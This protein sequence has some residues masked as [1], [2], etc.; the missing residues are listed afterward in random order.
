MANTVTATPTAHPAVPD[1][2]YPQDAASG[3]LPPAPW[4]G[5]L[6]DDAALIFPA[7]A[8][9]LWLALRLRR[10]RR[11]R[12]A[13]NRAENTLRG[14]VQ[15][16]SP[17]VEQEFFRMLVQQLAKGLGARYALVGELNAR[18]ERD[19][20][21]GLDETD[22]LDET[23]E[24]DNGGDTLRVLAAWLGSA[25]AEP[26]D[27]AL[28]GTPCARAL[29]SP[30]L[31]VYPDGVQGAFPEA[32]LH[33]S[34][35]IRSYMGLALR[36]AHGT[37]LG[38]LAVFH[39]KPMAPP[40]GEGTALMRVLAGRATAELERL[41]AGRALRE[42]E[43]RYRGLFENNHVV[44]LLID[45]ATR[46]I[47][48]ASPAAAAFYGWPRDVLRTM[49]ISAIN[50]LPPGE[51][52]G[53]LSSA[54]RGEKRRFRF[55]HRLAD[56]AIR[57]VE[58]NTGTLM[59]RGEPLLYSIITDVTE[60][61]RAEEAL[62]RSELRLRMLVE[63][64]GDAIY[65]VDGGGRI[66][67]A[68]PEA[69]HQT[70]HTREQLLRMSLFDIDEQLD[71]RVFAR[72]RAKLETAR[73][74]TF[75]TTHRTRGGAPLPVEVRMALMEEE[76]GEPLLLAIVR[77]S[78]ARKRAECELRC[79][80][81]AAEA[82]NRTKSEFLANM[83]HEIRTPLNG[84]M[85]M[86]QLLQA[87]PAKAMRKVYVGAATQSCRRLGLLLGDILDLSRIEAGKLELHDEPFEARAVLD[88]VRGLF[89]GPAA[90]RGLTLRVSVD[91]RIPRHLRGDAMRLRQ[92]LFNLVGNAVKFTD[93]GEVAVEAWRVQASRS[94]GCRVLFTVR[95]TGIG[96]AEDRLK[97]IF[98][99]FVQGET[100]STRRYQGAGLG[101]PIVRR[102]VRLM[103]GTIAVE[104][105]P[106]AGTAFSVS[107]PFRFVNKVEEAV[108]GPPAAD[109]PALRGRAILLAE[110]DAVNRLA[111][112][113]LLESMGARVTTADNGERAV[114]ALLADDFDCVLMDIQM[115]VMDGMEA[116]RRL[117]ALGQDGTRLDPRTLRAR[118]A[119][120]VIALTAHAMRGD[121]EQF[122]AA[123][124][125]GYLTKPVE[126][127]TLASAIVRAIREQG[128]REREPGHAM[129]AG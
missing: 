2:T 29:N 24:T 70:G 68:N 35:G 128:L 88:E 96:I 113:R 75:E 86:L 62:R 28:H 60:Q 47:R 56:G 108:A 76:E 117:R 41:R 127:A 55:R 91:R 83:S 109:A 46:A 119:T 48:D 12:R 11:A 120:P 30:D 104:S 45:P 1:I 85:G 38:V 64:A 89:E 78:S 115:P 59:L 26:F 39:D 10:A 97:D 73:K 17:L 65:I 54:A 123:G 82:A 112:T 58:A 124:M 16:T 3:V 25:P 125:D 66:L 95:D 6:I 9:L 27:Y 53:E 8:L 129:Q 126:A 79:A 122:L 34:L 107:L 61:R 5:R 94:R 13:L 110:D 32:E 19:G 106:D 102:L 105:T 111:V 57:D 80:K 67:D 90:E 15:V 87:D 36:D 21:A 42:S 40:T 74:A 23:G 7:A 50:T 93:H 81:E 69:E 77:D 71:Q 49:H 20:L 43:S 14:I 98:E 31:C 118:S 22:G 51:L 121:R 114:Q 63:S 103:R 52:R 99:P 18:D 101:L 84:I 4:W 72:L 100:A 37:P 116:T 33:L 92:V 44:A